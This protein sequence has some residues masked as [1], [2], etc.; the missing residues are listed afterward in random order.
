M[1]VAEAEEVA[2]QPVHQF[3]DALLGVRQEIGQFD[4]LRLD[5]INLGENDLERALE[6]LNLAGGVEEVAG[7]EAAR[8]VVAGVPEPGRDA[9]GAVA[10]L[11]MQV[12]RAVAVRAQLLFG[13][14]VNL[15]EVVPIAKLIDEAAAHFNSLVRSQESGVRS[16]R[17]E[18][19]IRRF[20]RAERPR[21]PCGNPAHF[22]LT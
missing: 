14:E 20:G 19:R 12:R 11:Q 17:P 6:E 18:I 22:G 21:W 2:A 8:D 4:L 5:A 9:A 7:V 1:R 13:D 3:R 10:Q 15:V 16:Q